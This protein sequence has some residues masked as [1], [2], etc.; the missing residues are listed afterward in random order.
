MLISELKKQLDTGKPIDEIIE[1]KQYL[2]I[3][4][5]HLIATKIIDSCITEDKNGLS[6]IDYFYKMFTTD[7]SLIVNY[8]NLE[9]PDELIVDYDYLAEM[10]YVEWI[11]NQIPKSEKNFIMNLVDSELAQMV[12]INNSVEGILSKNLLKIIEKIPSEKSIQ[13]I[14]KDI[15]KSINKIS[16]AN[17]EILKGMMNKQGDG[18]GK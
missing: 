3:I 13:K 6:K 18:D 11:I 9:F 12:G 15:P 4:E 7:I 10:G 17:L 14:I 2:S 5:K 16:P 1:I 8:T